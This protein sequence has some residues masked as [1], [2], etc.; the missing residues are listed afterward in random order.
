MV[1]LVHIGE[2]FSNTACEVIISYVASGLLLLGFFLSLM[3]N[4][5]PLVQ[6]PENIYE[7]PVESN[8]F[9]SQHHIVE[10]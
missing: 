8:T 6:E 9:I 3:L 2:C 10:F 4:P 7:Q 5:H 1:P